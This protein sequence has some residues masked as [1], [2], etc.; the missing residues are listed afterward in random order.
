[1]PLPD[2]KDAADAEFLA[3]LIQLNERFAAAL[4]GTL[5]RLLEAHNAFDPERP[6]SA[7]IDEFRA[8]LHTLAGSAATFGFS[9]L[10][11]RA[12]TLEQG[13]P[14]LAAFDPVAR[15]ARVDWL[16]GLR[17]FLAWAAFDL[18]RA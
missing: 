11:L 13:L 10:G 2:D 7:S 12:R 17:D 1:M 4:P 3:R 8:V 6:Q 14:A 18:Q 9:E 5:A 16:A 15:Q